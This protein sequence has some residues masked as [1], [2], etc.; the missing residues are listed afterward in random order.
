[1]GSMQ[2]NVA[3][4][5][6]DRAR[7]YCK[8][9]PALPALN[10]DNYKLAHRD[11]VSLHNAGYALKDISATV[12]RP[13][14]KSENIKENDSSKVPRGDA[15]R[16][17]GRI[18]ERDQKFRERIGA[19]SPVIRDQESVKSEKVYDL[20]QYK[21]FGNLFHVSLRSGVLHVLLADFRRE[22]WAP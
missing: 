9:R 21:S 14:P 18:S 6:P 12:P 10:D 2:E 7:V 4:I 17:G 15:P 8:D 11:V 22:F 3:Y 5:W 1:M 20:L 13:P 19:F 16:L